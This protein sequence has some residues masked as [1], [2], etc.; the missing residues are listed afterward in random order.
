MNLNSQTIQQYTRV[1]LYWLFGFLGNYGVV[2]A[3]DKRLLI[4]S[5][6]G[7]MINLAWTVYGTRING[8][9]EHVKEKTG[10]EKVTIEVNPDVI[11]P[12]EITQNTS[13]GIVAKAAP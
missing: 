9:L 8:L 4:V 10:V 1:A 3:D 5:I 13:S 2:V 11:K 12:A 7:T 6:V